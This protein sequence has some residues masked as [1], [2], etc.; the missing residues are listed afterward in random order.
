MSHEL[1]TPLNS[2]LILAEQL[3]SNPDG[4]LTPKQVEF[5]RTIRGSGKDL[6]KLIN[7]ILDLSKIE[8]G[9]MELDVVDFDVRAVVGDVVKLLGG[10]ARLKGLGL[11][12]TIDQAVPRVVRGDPCRVRQVLTNLMGNAV[13]FTSKGDVCIRVS[14]N[15]GEHHLL[16]FEVI[17]TGVGIPVEKL[18]TIFQPFV[19][20]DSSTCRKYGGTGLGLAISGQLVELMGG[21]SGV[22]SDIG[23]GS[24]FWFTVRVQPARQHSAVAPPVVASTAGV[25]QPANGAPHRQAHLLLAEDNLINE[26]VAVAMLTSAGYKVDVA[27]N[28]FEAVTAVEENDYDAILMDCQMPELNGYEATAMIRANQGAAAHVP[29]I[30]LTAGAL[31]EDRDRCLAAGMDDYISKPVSKDALVAMVDQWV[32]RLPIAV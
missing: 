7:D 1:R 25:S 9:N 22:S 27:R 13:K 3:S 5:A 21:D 4:N 26:K 17:D 8:A 29:I 18:A 16:R 11:N 32:S 14:R 19:Q 31:R 23:H 20:G 10:A 30:A 24:V 2:L 15:A 6:L 12:S 28:G